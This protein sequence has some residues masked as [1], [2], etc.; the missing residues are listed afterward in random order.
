LFQFTHNKL[1]YNNPK[2]N[3]TKRKILYG[4]PAQRSDESSLFNADESM[5]LLRLRPLFLTVMDGCIAN[6]D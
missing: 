6:M 4:T 5:L 1:D 3:Q 2:L